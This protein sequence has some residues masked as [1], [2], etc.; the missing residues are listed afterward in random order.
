MLPREEIHNNTLCAFCHLLGQFV[1]FWVHWSTLIQPQVLHLGL[2]TVIQLHQKLIWYV[3]FLTSCNHVCERSVSWKVLENSVLMSV[4]TLLLCCLS[5]Q[6]ASMSLSAVHS[7]VCCG[8]SAATYSTA[9][10]SSSVGMFSD[11][12]SHSN[13]LLKSRRSEPGVVP[14]ELA[15]A[16]AAPLP[17]LS[18][19]WLD[20]A[21]GRIPVR[22]Q[23]SFLLSVQTKLS[24]GG[25]LSY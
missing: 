13:R 17:T 8:L 15:A 1:F 7:Q 20:S 12:L 25:H 21:C 4:R 10:I 2:S 18:L 5:C 11:W 6:V 9:V 23:L 22:C 3:H 19:A 24:F 14:I 16:A